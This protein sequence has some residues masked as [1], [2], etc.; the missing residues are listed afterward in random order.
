MAKSKLQQEQEEPMAIVPVRMPLAL[1]RWA[2]RQGGGNASAHVRKL[3][4]DDMRG[5]CERRHG[6]PDRRRKR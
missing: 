5:F 3:I 6:T 2:R 1:E 4:E